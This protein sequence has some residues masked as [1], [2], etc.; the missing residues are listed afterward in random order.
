MKNSWLS[1]T[2]AALA[3]ILVAQPSAVMAQG[4]QNPGYFMPPQARPA[5]RPA[6]PA[7]NGAAAAT[8]A[9]TPAAVRGRGRGRHRRSRCSCR[10][11]R[12][13]P[14]IPKG[15]P[16][17]AAIVGVVSIPDALRVSTAYQQADKAFDDRHKK[18]DED[19]Q[20]EQAAL[21]DL[22]QAARQ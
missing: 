11:C 22:G 10:R 20:K 8:A 2:G 7:A 4:Q 14:R 1:L 16:T 17:P 9:E 3:L 15:P 18:L 21:R 6:R 19:A 13:F 5:A 12:K